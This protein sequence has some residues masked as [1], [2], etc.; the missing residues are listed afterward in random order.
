[1][2]PPVCNDRPVF[3][4]CCSADLW[5]VAPIQGLVPV[6]ARMGP[7][8]TEQ[9]KLVIS[10]VSTALRRSLIGPLLHPHACTAGMG[11]RRRS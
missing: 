8:P 3:S 5:C 1:M 6:D 9:R 11:V 10:G 7:E 4:L 2:S